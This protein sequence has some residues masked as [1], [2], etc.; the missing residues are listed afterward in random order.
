MAFAL[1]VLTTL[2]N[3][4]VHFLSHPDFQRLCDLSAIERPGKSLIEGAGMGLFSSRPIPAGTVVCL[5]PV[6]AIG[7]EKHFDS[8][9]TAFLSSDEDSLHFDLV[10]DAPGYRQFL[11]G[12]RP[13]FSLSAKH[14]TSKTPIFIDVNPKTARTPGWQGSLVNDGDVCISSSEDEVKRYYQTSR[15]KKNCVLVPMGPAPLM[16]YVTTRAVDPQEELLTTYGC[17]YWLSATGGKAVQLSPNVKEL[18]RQTAADLRDS[19]TLAARDY[20][21]D[22]A[23]L[24]RMFTELERGG[25]I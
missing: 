25:T 8:G 18:V 21:H 14:T 22:M 9:E 24:T 1:D 7:R 12:Q 11:I 17:E 2:Q 5:Y 15:A 4:E 3:P 16:A 19:A 6:H 23:A 10:G 13:L 20:A